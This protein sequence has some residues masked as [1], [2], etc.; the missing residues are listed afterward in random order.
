MK[1]GSSGET[2][3]RIGSDQEVGVGVERDDGVGVPITDN[4]AVGFMTLVVDKKA[5]QASNFRTF[6]LPIRHP[7]FCAPQQQFD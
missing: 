6:L 2:C 7:L 4:K 3:V 5:A 1:A